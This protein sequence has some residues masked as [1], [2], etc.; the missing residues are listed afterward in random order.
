M[1]KSSIRLEGVIPRSAPRSEDFVY[2]L[3]KAVRTT[4]GEAKTDLEK[5][6][7][8]WKSRPEFALVIR[9]QK[10]E[11]LVLTNSNIWSYLDQGVAPHI[12]TP[13]RAKVLRFQR[14]YSAKTE[15]KVL[16]SKAG[17]KSGPWVSKKEVNWP[18]IEARNWGEA[19][20]KKYRKRFQ[21]RINI[22]MAN[23]ARKSHRK[24][25]APRQLTG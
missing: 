22:G 12:I 11:F 20:A 7:E 4:G 17:G 19:I 8:T 3:A 10:A 25:T 18:G 16:S 21:A 6:T 15:V 1:A 23:A 13:K 14:D 5:T 9:V 2:E 24:G